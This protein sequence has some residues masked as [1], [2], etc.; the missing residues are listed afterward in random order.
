MTEVIKGEKLK[1]ELQGR[2][3]LTDSIR[4]KNIT[5]GGTAISDFL[6]EG[7]L[8]AGGSCICYRATRF[9]ENG[10]MA[11]TGTLK[12]FY[13]VDF[14]TSELSYNLKRRD[15]DDGETA[16]QLYSKGLTADNFKIARD[17]FFSAYKKISELKFDDSEYDN[18]FAPIAIYKG[19]AKNED[20]HDNYTIYIWNPGD[21]AMVG[22]DDYLKTMQ[23]EI[24]AKIENP[25]GSPDLFLAEKLRTVIQ[26]IKA[27][28]V[29]IE[30]LHLDNLLHLDIKPSNFGI[31]ML[32]EN[33]GDHISVSL[34]DVNTIYSRSNPLARTGGTPGFRAPEIIGDFENNYNMLNIG[35][36]SDIYSLGATLYNSLVI[37]SKDNRGVYN[38]DNFDQIDA[39]IS[40]SMLIEPS[41]F[42]SK[43]DLHDILTT[44]LKRSLARKGSDYLKFDNYISVGEFI[45][46]LQK[47]DDIIRIQISQAR[48]NGLDKKVITQVVD[49]E[50][51]YDDKIDTG[52]TGA[53]QCLLYDKPLYDYVDENGKVNILVLGAGVYSQKFLDIAFEMS[54]VK[55]CYLD[56]TVITNEKEKDEARYLSTRPEF[57]NYF[58]VNGNKPALD[59]YGS[60]RFLN[61]KNT[62]N[63]EETG[64]S[65]SLDN[66]LITEDTLEESDKTFS[67][68]FISLVD[69]YLN[70]KVAEDLALSGIIKAS[71][72]TEKAIINF[73]WYG[74]DDEDDKSSGF[75][76]KHLNIV[77]EAAAL[78]ITL[79][80]TITKNTFVCHKDYNFIKRMAFNCHL[81]WNDNLGDIKKIYGQFR[82]TYNFSSSL[83]MAL[84]CK[85]K[86]KSIG[87][88]LDNVTNEKDKNER[89]KLLHK[90]TLNYRNKIGLGLPYT[91][92][93]EEQKNNLKNL[94]MYEHRRWNVNAICSSYKTM[95]EDE[96]EALKTDNKDKKSRKHPCLVPC[97]DSWALNAEIWKKFSKWDEPDIESTEDFKNLDALDKMSV[98][99]HRHFMNLAKDFSFEK[100]ENDAGIIRRYLYDNP[101]ALAAFNSY[102]I[103][104]RAVTSR[105][106]RNDTA[107]ETY[108]HC[109]DVLNKIIK[110]NSLQNAEEI[111]N[112]INNIETVFAPVRHAYDYTDYKGKDQRIINGL[113][114]ILNYSTSVRICTPFIETTSDN[115]NWFENV[116][117]SL[118]IN[119]SILTYLINI[120]D[121]N[122]IVTSIKDALFNVTQVMDNH[123]LQTRISLIIYTNAKSGV[124]SDN[125]KEEIKKELTEISNRIYNVEIVE[126]KSQKELVFRIKNTL[127][128]NL[129][130]SS[131]FTA[132]ELKDDFISGTIN[133]IG[134]PLIKT[135]EF[136]SAEKSF[137]TDEDYIWFS[138][139]PFNSHLNI[140]DMF[141]AHGRLSVYEEPELHRDY[142]KIWD[143]CYSDSNL[144]TRANKS[145]AWKL[146]CS[147]FKSRVEETD[148]ITSIDVRKNSE[149]KNW[150]SEEM[151]LFAPAFC[152]ASLEKIFDYLKLPKVKLISQ[153]SLISEHNSATIKLIFRSSQDTQNAILKILQNPYWLIDSSKIKLISARD[154]RFAQI[155]FDS[156]IVSGLSWTA[157][158][159]F[160]KSK[161]KEYLFNQAKTAFEYLVKEGYVIKN[162][163]TANNDELSFCFPSSQIKSLLT[164]EGQLLEIYSY[165]KTLDEGYYDEVKTG[166]EV[167]KLKE[168]KSGFIPT[169]EF[170]M[171]AIKGF[172]TQFVEIKARGNLE[173]GFYQKLESNGH[174]FGINKK[175]TLIS[176]F[177]DYSKP[178]IKDSNIEAIA[179]GKE[180]YN[181]ETIYG[182]KD[183][184]RIAK[185]LVE[186]L[187]E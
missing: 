105:K 71:D 172:Q 59:D 115:N 159:T 97:G 20:D 141:I 14:N 75:E 111:K 35:V 147:A 137:V 13:P 63:S 153:D 56:V 18:F 149:E 53:M 32:R 169:Q 113:P 38:V 47:A 174:K 112:R 148:V 138:D 168:D 184:N 156:L 86:L 185:A 82:S 126:T 5:E 100:I 15:I 129:K 19:I 152:K 170:D 95:T 16:N 40:H 151:S 163:T 90:L 76:E 61:V 136:N 173:Q 80:P 23:E 42:N 87:L 92:K 114:F 27:L 183:I 58:W 120:G 175:L 133:A 62:F 134:N 93:T 182:I 29:G 85:Y 108:R 30:K 187:E 24:S 130:S 2:D 50:T 45:E 103:S 122:T 65:D 66:A 144:L 179:K 94:T 102:L 70:K 67:Y 145:M 164:N 186:S 131:K 161:N 46:D 150:V 72:K 37:L 41:E 140:E 91:K 142:K 28:A 119:P 107:Q 106:R 116:A 167:Q 125:I 98:K 84:S 25:S 49:K 55:N 9:Y 31:R 43:A 21:N 68:V 33:D 1:E 7:V 99:L 101:E 177:G 176:D 26:A 110:D 3:A 4:L 118:V 139:I 54:Q 180:D 154:G 34:Y 135:Y 12:E 165:Y 158:K 78:N 181:V 155:M 124:I 10:D 146:L 162:E 69:Q 81:I 22:F 104:M 121:C 127:E 160:F 36:K 77:N 123:N 132:I 117:S 128:T 171:I 109:R 83:S 79:T 96:Y 51:Y 157:V 73:V 60:I 88:S 143:N 64:F 44:M 6:I 178:Q 8:H 57:H 17:E 89:A 48:E 166:L 11:E 74:K 39:D 52:A